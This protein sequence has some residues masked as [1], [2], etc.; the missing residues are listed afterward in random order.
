MWFGVSCSYSMAAQTDSSKAASKL[1]SEYP[2][3]DGYFNWQ[4]WP[5]DVDK[6][7]TVSPDVAFQ[8]ALKNAGRTGPYMM[9]KSS[10]GVVHK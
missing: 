1:I 9:G 2:S 6:N 8:S 4:A 10:K 7:I 5:L 3:I